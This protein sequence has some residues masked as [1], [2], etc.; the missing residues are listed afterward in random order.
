MNFTQEDVVKS[1]LPFYSLF[2]FHFARLILCSFPSM[3]AQSAGLSF[4]SF[5]SVRGDECTDK[6]RKY[7]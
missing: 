3:Q 5:F 4:Y 7:I 1:S 2:I 6:N